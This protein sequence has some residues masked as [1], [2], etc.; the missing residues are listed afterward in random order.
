MLDGVQPYQKETPAKAFSCKFSK[1]FSKNDIFCRTHPSRCLNEMNQKKICLI[2]S[3]SKGFL[4][5]LQTCGL[6]AFPKEAPS[7]TLFYE[8]CEVLQSHFYRP[9]MR[10]CFWFPVTFSIYHLF[11]QQQIS[12]FIAKLP[13][14]FRKKK[15]LLWR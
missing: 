15:C 12:S 3:R 7:Q 10:D 1:F 4:V 8:N 13:R 2:Y 14:A 11:Y 9:L 5:Q 6:T